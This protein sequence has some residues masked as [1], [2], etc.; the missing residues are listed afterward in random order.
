MISALR[1]PRLFPAISVTLNLAATIRY[2]V[3]GDYPRSVYWAAAAVLTSTIT[4]WV[5]G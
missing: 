5:K 3:N 1:S 4:W 2:A